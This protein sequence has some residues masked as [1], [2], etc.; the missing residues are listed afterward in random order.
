[1]Q[2][3]NDNIHIFRTVKTENPFAQIDKR[4]INDKSISW[5]TKGILIYLLSKP[6]DWTA[7]LSDII[8]HSTDGRD[9]IRSAINEAVKAGYIK[10]IIRSFLIEREIS[11]PWP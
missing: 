5:K 4:L 1:M 9:A 6:N 2:N 8:G 3:T 10:R 7:Q 11:L